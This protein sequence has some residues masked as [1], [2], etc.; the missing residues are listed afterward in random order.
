MIRS[1]NILTDLT[2]DFI[3]MTALE[4]TT[5]INLPCQVHLQDDSLKVNPIL[6]FCVHQ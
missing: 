5:S 6:D 2:Y 4:R 3:F 1:Y